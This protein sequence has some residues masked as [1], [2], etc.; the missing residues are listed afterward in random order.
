MSL[1]RSRR[2]FTLIELLVV[3][4]IIAILIGLLLPA[5]QKVREAAAMTQCRNHLKQQGIAIHAHHDQAG[6][7]P[8][9]GLNPW[10]AKG[11]WPYYIL[12]FIEQ[13]NLY[14][15][16]AGSGS[17]LNVDPARY[18][19]GPKIFFC[20]AR[21]VVATQGGRFLM[22]YASATPANSP[23]SWDQFWY[24]D[25]WGDGWIGSRYRG[26]IVRGAQRG[27]VWV[28]SK[29]T[30]AGITDGTSNTLLVGEK[31]LHPGRYFTGDWHDDAGWGD[32][33]DPDVIRYTGF[34]PNHDARYDNQ[35][36]WEGYRFGASHPVGINALMG[37]GS[38]RTIAYDINPTTFNALG[39]RDGGET[40]TNF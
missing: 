21:R 27:G 4:A 1:Q 35:G 40:L 26:I 22:D 7:M 5:V 19:P 12:P 9:G 32:G 30:M 34:Q 2:G 24:G 11:S 28:G 10:E 36:G 15:Q 38:V 23:N 37:D 16:A 3:I 25:I 29:T 39:T 6:Y 20:P 17:S 14:R 13:D 31:Q 8:P 18:Q 33:W